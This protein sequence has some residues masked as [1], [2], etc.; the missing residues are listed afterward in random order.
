MGRRSGFRRSGPSKPSLHK[1]LLAVC[2][3]PFH[4][5]KSMCEDAI[6]NAFDHT[7]EESSRAQSQAHTSVRHWSR[8]EPYQGPGTRYVQDSS[9]LAAAS[10]GFPVGSYPGP[11]N[12]LP[13]PKKQLSP[14]VLQSSTTADAET[15]NE[16]SCLTLL[17][18]TYCDISGSRRPLHC[19]EQCSGCLPYEM[20]SNL[21]HSDEHSKDW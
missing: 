7:C 6:R 1:L 2:V 4:V 10:A 11:V 14:L 12:S 20:K 3:A 18:V 5:H 16:P 19:D 13:L 9:T 15:H 17:V 21:P 8:P